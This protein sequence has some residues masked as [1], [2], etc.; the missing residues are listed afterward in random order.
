MS[1]FRSA[2]RRVM[3]RAVVLGCVLGGLLWAGCGPTTE[4]L[5]LP[6]AAEE[7]AAVAP[8]EVEVYRG[9]SRVP[10]DYRRVALVEARA[11]E[12]VG[13]SGGVSQLAL[14]RAARQEAGPVGANAIVID[15]VQTQ[16]LTETEVKADTAGYAR[17]ESSRSLGRAVFLAIRE[18]RPCEAPGS[19]APAPTQPP[20]R[21]DAKPRRW[22]GEQGT[23][24]A[25]HRPVRSM[26]SR[27]RQPTPSGSPCR[28][29]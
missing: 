10:C 14:I 12:E 6:G 19:K 9:L 5:R 21:E 28:S 29:G 27:Q 2:S 22:S 23:R 25:T 7:L 17:T 11:S 8:A 18:D 1:G 4:V 16:L 15:S 20:Q 3:S 24:P 13:P 26:K